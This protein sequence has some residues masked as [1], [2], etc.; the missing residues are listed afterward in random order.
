MGFLDILV[1]MASICIPLSYILQIKSNYEHKETRDINVCGVI[2]ADIAY[3]VYGI[4]SGILLENAFIIKY[5]LSFVLCTI[6]IAQIIIYRRRKLEWHDDLD[7][8]CSGE[9]KDR[10][11]CGNELEPHWKHCPDCGSK[12]GL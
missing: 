5:G 7:R 2:A 1:W 10:L 9:V 12:I 11:F 8:Y 3:L 6:M 4:K